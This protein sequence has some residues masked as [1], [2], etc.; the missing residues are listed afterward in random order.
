M[1]YFCD[2]SV[3]LLLSVGFGFWVFLTF[4]FFFVAERTSPILNCQT[5]LDWGKYVGEDSN[6]NKI[7][8]NKN[9]E[10]V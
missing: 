2:Q 3:L 4:F 9:E 10:M 8:T 7:H 5:M 6:I 1:V